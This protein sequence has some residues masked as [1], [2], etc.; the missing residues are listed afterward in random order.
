MKKLFS[1]LFT[2]SII[3]LYLIFD[4][5]LSFETEEKQEDGVKRDEKYYQTKMCSEFGGKTEY[6]LFDKARVDCLTSEYAIEVDFAK[7]WAEGIGQ[8]LYYAEITKKK[9]AVALIVEDGDEKYLNRIK[10][11]ADKFDI[12]II[13]LNK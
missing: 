8:A 2:L 5:N 3:I 13:V 11:V 9:P 4:T 1:L 10:T 6:V 7:K 12:K